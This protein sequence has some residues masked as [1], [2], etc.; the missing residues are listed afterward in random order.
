LKLC[1]FV[2]NVLVTVSVCVLELTVL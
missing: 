2:C 1:D